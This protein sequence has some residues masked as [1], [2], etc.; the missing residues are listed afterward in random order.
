MVKAK[1][2][3]GIWLPGNDRHFQRHLE[4]GPEFEGKGTYQFSKISLALHLCMSRRA[5]FR[6]AVDIGAHVGLWSRVLAHHFAHVTAFEA[7]PD[8][9]ELWVR[10]VE[11]ANTRLYNV[12]LSGRDGLGLHL[13]YV[14]DNSG[15]AH[16]SEH[17]SGMAMDSRTLDSYN[18]LDVDFIKIDVEG[19]EKFVIEGGEE[20]IKRNRPIMVVE[21]K[22]GNGS[23]YG[24][25]DTA[26]IDLL[27]SWGMVTAKIKAGDYFMVWND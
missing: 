5:H 8:L 7:H 25:S 11:N 19:F 4:K 13:D 6:H 9:A 17:A 2:V 22:P 26:A 23:R 18:L 12:A 3:R 21:Q 27:H 14:D 24:I 15:N 20:T 16:I 1:N 10:N